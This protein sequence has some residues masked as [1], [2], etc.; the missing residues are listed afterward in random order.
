MRTSSWSEAEPVAGASF[1]PWKCRGPRPSAL[2]E[3]HR[4]SLVQVLVLGGTSED[5]VRVAR[6]F[7]E[8]SPLR[9]GAFVF[10]DGSQDESAIRG[11]LLQ[12]LDFSDTPARNPLRASERGTLFVD[13]VDALSTGTQRLLLALG[14]ASAR[15][16]LGAWRGRL[17]AGSDGNLGCMAREGDFQPALFDLLDK[18][19]I[20]LTPLMGEALA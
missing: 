15:D 20:E 16:G 2:L 7:H 1:L 12:W 5:R 18:V 8:R 19:R 13:R 4:N 6:A 17:M 3:L 10:V 14:M 9:T 11:A